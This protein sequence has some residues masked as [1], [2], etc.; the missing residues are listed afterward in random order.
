MSAEILQRGFGKFITISSC[1]LFFGCSSETESRSEPMTDIVGDGPPRYARLVLPEIRNW[2]MES[3]VKLQGSPLMVIW[4]VSDYAPGTEPTG[5]Q[6]R[7]AD[8]LVARC[9]ESA[10]RNGWSDY[11][12]GLADGYELLRD[13]TRHYRKNELLFDDAILDPN[14]PEVLMYYP[15]PEGKK[16]AGFMFQTKERYERGPQLGGPL[17]VWH[18]HVFN[19]LR[20]VD[21]AGGSSGFAG[22]NGCR[23]G[24]F[25]V[26]RS[27]EMVH[28]WLIDRT[29]GPFA[30][31]MFVRRDELLPAVAKRMLEFGF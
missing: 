30:S 4:E 7:A 22:S 15:T 27:R 28:V 20:C 9:Y 31:G 10:L 29:G 13:D 2:K 1:L 5:E 17:T 24:Y 3:D 8:D 18:Y 12:K 23:E 6:K 26:H 21:G 14:R 19:R 25:G 11:E 16:L